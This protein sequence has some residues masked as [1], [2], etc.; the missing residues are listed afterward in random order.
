MSLHF[1]CLISSSSSMMF[2]VLNFR[3]HPHDQVFWGFSPFP[4]DLY[5]T[6]FDIKKGF[7]Q[8]LAA[9]AS[10]YCYYCGE[11]LLLLLRVHP[12]LR[13]TASNS[14]LIERISSSIPIF[15]II[16]RSRYFFII[17]LIS[18]ILWNTPCCY[19]FLFLLLLYQMWDFF[20]SDL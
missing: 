8:T 7:I 4:T 15:R 3:S 14:F 18:F 20:L 12:W 2:Y 17:F 6:V 11:K 16:Y 5:Y 13:P 1:Y 19:F 10:N 9:A